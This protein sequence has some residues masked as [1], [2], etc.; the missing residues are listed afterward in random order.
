MGSL[1]PRE[2]SPALP[3]RYVVVGS[4]YF[5]S[6]VALAVVL[7]IG[8][9]VGFGT[10]RPLPHPLA[11]ATAPLLTAN[12]DQE[13]A[14]AQAQRTEAALRPRLEQL[15]GQLAARRAQ[16]PLPDAG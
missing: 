2:S 13:R 10:G 1:P 5:W 3:L 4:R 14:L 16:C 7:A 15:R 8:A 12:A 6:V 9:A 11:D